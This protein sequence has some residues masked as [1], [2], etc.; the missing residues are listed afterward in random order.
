MSA[1]PLKIPMPMP[2]SSSPRPSAPIDSYPL[3]EFSQFFKAENNLPYPTISQHCYYLKLD[4]KRDW[5]AGLAIKDSPVFS[6]LA[7][8]VENELKSLLTT[9]DGFKIFLVHAQKDKFSSRRIL[10]TIIMQ[11]TMK[12]TTEKLE[13]LLR[14]HIRKEEKIV[15]LRAYLRDL[16]VRKIQHDEFEHLKI[17]G[18]NPC[19]TC[20]KFI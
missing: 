6:T 14:E 3:N 8:E 18:C 10:L 4:I 17:Y 7:N 19:D 16:K 9:D 12:F 1:S 20:G 15:N 2:M 11:T 5:N 13:A